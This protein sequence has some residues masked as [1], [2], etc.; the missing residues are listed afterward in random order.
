MLLNGLFMNKHKTLIGR[1]QVGPATLTWCFTR[2]RR[3]HC[4]LFGPFLNV[5]FDSSVTKC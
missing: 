5:S 4:M 3:V 1:M 2:K